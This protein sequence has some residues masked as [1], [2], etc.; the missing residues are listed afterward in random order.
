MEPLRCEA[1][2]T[3]TKGDFHWLPVYCRQ[4]VGVRGYW[5][6]DARAHE[7]TDHFVTYCSIEGHRENCERRFPPADPLHTHFDDRDAN[8][9]EC[10]AC[11]L[12]EARA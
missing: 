8:L 9:I 6:K 7:N 11:E 12:A 1:I 4:T 3:W 5:A 10:P 2:V